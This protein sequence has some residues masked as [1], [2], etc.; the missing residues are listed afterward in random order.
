MP[1]FVKKK[2]KANT[3]FEQ[4]LELHS[5]QDTCNLFTRSDDEIRGYWEI[6]P[7]IIFLSEIKNGF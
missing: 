5:L 2:K 3:W 6:L 1:E 4:L 7:K